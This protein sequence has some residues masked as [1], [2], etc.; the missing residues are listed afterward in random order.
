MIRQVIFSESLRVE[1]GNT[2]GSND[3]RS[4]FNSCLLRLKPPKIQLLCTWFASNQT[5]AT[6]SNWNPVPSSS[7]RHRSVHIA[8]SLPWNSYKNLFCVWKD[9]LRGAIGRSVSNSVRH[10]Q[11]MLISCL[12][13]LSFLFA[14]T[15]KRKV[16]DVDLKFFPR[17]L[18]LHLQHT[19]PLGEMGICKD[20]NNLCGD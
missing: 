13:L 14:E 7:H 18:G 8:S 9:Q 12:H 20:W 19:Q 2:Q 11:T 15:G 17:W 5:A 3:K 6:S 16:L 10:G 1:G 4:G